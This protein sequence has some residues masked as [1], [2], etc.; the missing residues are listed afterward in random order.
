MKSNRTTATELETDAIEREGR[1]R[2]HQIADVI[3]KN[4][5]WDANDD[6]DE[7]RSC[8]QTLALRSCEVV[9]D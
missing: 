9:R 6:M 7:S 2:G 8:P 1:Y 4:T 5:V 3:Y